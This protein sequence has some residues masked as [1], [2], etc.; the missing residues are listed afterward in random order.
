MFFIANLP[1]RAFTPKKRPLREW[2]NAPEVQLAV[3][4]RRLELLSA[5]RLI[6]APGRSAAIQVMAA[7]TYGCFNNSGEVGVWFG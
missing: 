3:M 2:A 1:T 6:P 7:K 4:E 5:L